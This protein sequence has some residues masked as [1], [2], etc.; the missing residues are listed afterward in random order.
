LWL[1]RAQ[2]AKLSRNNDAAKAT[3]ILKRCSAFARF[4]GDGRICLPNN[5]AERGVRGIALGR[6]SWLESRRRAGG[7]DAS[8]SAGQERSVD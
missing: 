5:A 3:N 2:R 7:G 4:L 6:K 8:S 1:T